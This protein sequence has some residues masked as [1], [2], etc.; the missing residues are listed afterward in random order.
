MQQIHINLSSMR[1]LF[2]EMYFQDTKLSSGTA[3]VA[4]LGNLRGIVTNRH[5]VTGRHQSTGAPLSSHGGV[6]DR[7]VVWHNVGTD[8]PAWSPFVIPLYDGEEKRWL[9]H[10]SL[11]DR[12]D[13]AVLPIEEKPGVRLYPYD[14]G[15][16]PEIIQRPADS[17]SVVGFP[18]GRASSGRLAIWAT[19]FIASEPDF[20]Y[21]DLP[22]TLIDCRSRQGQS[23]SPV[24]MQ[25]NE[26]YWGPDGLMSPYDRSGKT[27]F[28]GIYSGRISPESDIGMVWWA[29]AIGETLK[30][31]V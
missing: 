14:L 28:V 13:I 20:P 29:T 25:R 9:E 21:D 19:G 6:P 18:F 12:A 31:T 30:Q 10:P 27:Q 3:F 8:F 15:L 7:I 17:V 26:V 5:N 4:T 24:I 2:I 1:S 11:G 23:G 16:A 22:V